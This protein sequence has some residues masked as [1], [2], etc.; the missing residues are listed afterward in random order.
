MI[1]AHQGMLNQQ[2]NQGLLNIRQSEITYYTNLNTAF[3]TQAALIGGFTYGVF[4]GDHTGGNGNDFENTV[5]AIYWV[6][7]AGTMVC[8]IFIILTTMFMHVLGPG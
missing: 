5:Q 1:R 3:G 8:A 6:V 2:T 7:A 4:L